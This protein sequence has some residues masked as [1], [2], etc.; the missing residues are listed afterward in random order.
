MKV[1]VVYDK[2]NL[3]E[4]RELMI[5][6]VYNVLSKRYQ[7]QL[8]AFE[9]NLFEKIVMFDAVFNLSTA[10]KQIHVPV[11]LE[12]LKIPYTGS[13]S[14]AHA[15]CIDKV[16]TKIILSYYGIPTASFI[17]VDIKEQVPEIQFYPAIVKPSCEGSAKGLDADSVVRDYDS[18]VRKVRDIHTRF[19][20]PALVEQFIDGREFSVGILAGEVLPILEIDFSTLP[21]GLER[22]YSYRV[23][24]EYGDH[25]RYVC[26]AQIDEDL[27]RKIKDYALKAF[28]VLGL[29][30][31]ARMD[32][33]VKEN[34]I[35][36][37]EV[38]SL[39][40]LTPN[41]SDIIKM[42][43]AAGY[44]YDDLILKIFEDALRY[45]ER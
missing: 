21:D 37:L 13:T 34:D 16:K 22:F 9:D 18:L 26:P 44:S 25:T 20:Q 10:S 30:N 27:E 24:H 6:S 23:K 39:P 36:F 28:E 11:I 40:M 3:D 1:A 32:L 4:A 45:H 5:Q 42:A 31:Y 12:L 14:Q 8:I 35:Y 15:I 38:N 17:S 33:R 19:K 41:Y 2:S 43:Q 7:V 29:R